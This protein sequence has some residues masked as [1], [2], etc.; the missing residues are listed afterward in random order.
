MRSPFLIVAA[1]CL[2]GCAA[3]TST[4]WPAGIESLEPAIS[5]SQRK[6]TWPGGAVVVAPG[7]G[8]AL[9]KA[10]WSG[11]WEGWAC[12]NFTCDTKLVVLSVTNDGAKGMPLWAGTA[13]SPHEVR[14][15]VF[16]ADE[17]HVVSGEPKFYYRMRKTGEVEMM[18]TRGTAM[19]WGVLTKSQ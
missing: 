8:V 12:Q 5:Q 11:R 3:T 19:G 9:Q 10:R 2:A 6:A 18:R 1:T 17:L 7:A 16:V 15:A 4:P 14:D 13:E